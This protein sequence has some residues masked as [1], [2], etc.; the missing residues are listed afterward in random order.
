MEGHSFGQTEFGQ[1]IGGKQLRGAID[2]N[3]FDRQPVNG[4]EKGQ[5]S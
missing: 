5:Q 1:M 2:A 3:T 4:I